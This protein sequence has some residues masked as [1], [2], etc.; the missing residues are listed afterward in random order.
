MREAAGAQSSASRGPCAVSGLRKRASADPVE[1]AQAI[2]PVVDA[3][4]GKRPFRVHLDPSED[5]E[6]MANAVAD[7]MRREINCN[8]VWIR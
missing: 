3:P 4:F 2:A 1:V 6:E 8:R 5:G 7:W